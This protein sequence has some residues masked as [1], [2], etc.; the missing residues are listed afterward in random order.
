MFILDPSDIGGEDQGIPSLADH[1]YFLFYKDFD[2]SSCAEA[3]TFILERNLMTSNK[4]PLIKLIINSY[5]GDTNAAFSLIDTIRG[6]KVPIYTYGLGTIASSGLMTFI[7]G[8]KGHRYITKNTSILSHQ[9]SWGQ[10]GK[11]HELF[12]RVKE[13]EL[14][15]KRMIDHYKKC[16]GLSEKKV[17]EYLLPPEDRWLSAE[18]AI[19]FNLADHIVEFK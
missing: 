8:K 17:K 11:E 18:E 4:P 5:G 3:M 14:T 1:H 12:A 13:F 19:E 2:A 15:S 6:S 16:T 10:Y 9:Y 7:A